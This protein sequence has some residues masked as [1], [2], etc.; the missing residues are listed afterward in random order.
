MPLKIPERNSAGIA[1]RSWMMGIG[2]GENAGGEIKLYI[3]SKC[4]FQ[5]FL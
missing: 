4:N 2:F 3:V 1:G 5:V